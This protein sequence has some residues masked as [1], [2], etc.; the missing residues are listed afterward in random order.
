MMAAT[1][2]LHTAVSCFSWRVRLQ[3]FLTIPSFVRN[4]FES[5][6]LQHRSLD[7]MLLLSQS[8]TAYLVQMTL[9]TFRPTPPH[10]VKTEKVCCVVVL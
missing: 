10:S 3:T 4:P 9:V 8:A 7:L 6:A 1:T 2:Y 5:V